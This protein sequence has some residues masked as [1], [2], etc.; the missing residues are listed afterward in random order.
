MKK[1]INIIFLLSSIFIIAILLFAFPRNQSHKQEVL[2][3]LLELE[4]REKQFDLACG[5]LQ[6]EQEQMIEE[7]EKIIKE[8]NK[9]IERNKR[10]IAL[11]E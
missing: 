5:K 9:V 4:Q 6:R 8:N 1:K 10:Y 7:N 3:Y 2:S 11:F